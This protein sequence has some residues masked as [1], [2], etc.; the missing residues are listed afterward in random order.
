MPTGC[1]S[2]RGPEPGALGGRCFG[3]LSQHAEAAEAAKNQFAGY[4]LLDAIVGNTDRHHE[5]WGVVRER[6][7]RRWVGHL[8]PS[9]DHASSLGR[10]LPEAKRVMRLAKG[11]VPAYAE[12]ARG[13]IYLPGR[14]GRGPSLLD[15]VR[16]SMPTIGHYFRAPLERLSSL[17]DS[18]VVEIM[19][20][21]PASWMST[22]AKEFAASLIRYNR[23]RLLELVP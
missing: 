3:E 2:I 5:N 9:F 12:R 4:L 13:A 1:S 20:R 11:T 6:R 21:I 19:D 18:D 7:E 22:S 14:T 17:R 15:L 16:D 8:A 10:E 23:D